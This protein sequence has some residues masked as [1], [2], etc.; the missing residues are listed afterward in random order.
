MAQT[1]IE[2]KV[3]PTTWKH[4]HKRRKEKAICKKSVDLPIHMCHGSR[5]EVQILLPVCRSESEGREKRS[6]F[7]L[8]LRSS[9]PLGSSHPI[10]VYRRD[11]ISA[12]F[13]KPSKV[14]APMTERS[15]RTAQPPHKINYENSRRNFGYVGHPLVK[16]NT[17]FEL[18]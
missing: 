4:Q 17:A 15:P 9:L 12:C 18:Q 6:A 16:C 10:T 2:A 13:E 3:G 1:G 8:R 14:S 5:F 7:L 11:P